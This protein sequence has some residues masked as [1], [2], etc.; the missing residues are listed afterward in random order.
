MT[1]GCSIEFTDN[2]I[3]GIVAHCYPQKVKLLQN[4]AI[5][6]L[7]SEFKVGVAKKVCENHKSADCPVV[8]RIWY[9]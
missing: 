7:D 4:L 3:V 2:R 5:G 1:K 8:L 6:Y 9:L